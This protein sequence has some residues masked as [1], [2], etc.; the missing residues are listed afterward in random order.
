MTDAE[1]RPVSVPLHP[2]SMLQLLAAPRR[3]V[4]SSRVE[5]WRTPPPPMIFVAC[6][7][8]HAVGGCHGDWLDATRSVEDLSH[9]IDRMLSASPT[10]GSREWA[11]LDTTGFAGVLV[12]PHEA[13]DHVVAV[14]RWIARWVADDALA[15]AS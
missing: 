11:I 9:A 6:V 15:I 8:D 5:R 2:L 1:G 10:H 13:L 4:P 12:D 14:A 7:A 3:P